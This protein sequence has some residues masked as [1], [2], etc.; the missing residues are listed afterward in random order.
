MQY[1]QG[2]YGRVFLL[3][4]E[5]KDDLLEE[6]KKLALKEQVKVGTVLLLGGMRTAAL[7]A[8]PKE[9]MIPPEPT[10]VDFDD[11][12]EVLGFGTLLWNGNEPAIHLHGAIGKGKETFTG[13]IRRNSSV[14]LVIEAVITEILG[15][16]AHKVQDEKA[17]L[18]MLKFR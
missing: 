3:K 9:P 12:R 2:S 17:G 11:G 4:F 6:I 7:V 5:D 8:G 14:F 15:I 10:W 16:A 18:A 1:R 13:C